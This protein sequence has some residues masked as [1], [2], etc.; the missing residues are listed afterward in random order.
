MLKREN[1]GASLPCNCGELPADQS[2]REMLEEW[3][4]VAVDWQSESRVSL[5]NCQPTP[6]WSG[7]QI[8]VSFSLLV[9]SLAVLSGVQNCQNRQED[10]IPGSC[11]P[12]RC[13]L[14]ATD[15]APH[16]RSLFF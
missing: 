15:L 12:D 2:A 6:L 1:R 10:S 11:Y 14:Q 7:G 5:P 13:T 16:L 4:I 9:L 3:R 8:T